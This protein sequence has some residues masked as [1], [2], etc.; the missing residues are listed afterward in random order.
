MDN[1]FC[2]PFAGIPI[3]C[4]LQH[5]LASIGA[6][7]LLQTGYAKQ[8]HLLKDS[9]QVSLYFQYQDSVD[10]DGYSR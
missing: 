5:L 6:E 1:P 10:S 7:K 8:L 4:L 2:R 3:F 9:L